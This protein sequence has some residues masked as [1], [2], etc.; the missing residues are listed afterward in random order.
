MKVS[1]RS[2]S[3]G[4]L[5]SEDVEHQAELGLEGGRAW[6]SVEVP[7]LAG[8]VDSIHREHWGWKKLWEQE[9]SREA[10]G[11]ETGFV[12]GQ[13]LQYLEG[14]VK[15]LEEELALVSGSTLKH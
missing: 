5:G 1:S 15:S 2:G 12:H 11:A 6:E 3:I 13:W 9:L 8:L 10:V 4:R 7:D 14:Q